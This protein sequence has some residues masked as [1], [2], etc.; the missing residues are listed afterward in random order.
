MG[1]EWITRD[2][3]SMVRNNETMIVMTLNLIANANAM[4]L[5][6]FRATA[7][8]HASDETMKNQWNFRLNDTESCMW[9]DDSWKRGI[10]S[11]TS[12]AAQ[13]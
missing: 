9:N 4:E 5:K 7:E 3:E 12:M 2:N 13:S 8:A 11:M 6:Q 10:G 1:V